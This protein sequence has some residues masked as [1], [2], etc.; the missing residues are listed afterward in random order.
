MDNEKHT[1]DE[2]IKELRQMFIDQGAFLG[3]QEPT[4]I[5]I[6]IK[7]LSDLIQAE[8][9]RCEELVEAEREKIKKMVKEID[10]RM[11]FDHDGLKDYI[12]QPNNPT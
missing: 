6:C 12:T 8:R 3:I 7:Q 4:K 5:V 9:Q 2:K 10:G 1:V 11:Y